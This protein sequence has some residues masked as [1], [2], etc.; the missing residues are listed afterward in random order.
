MQNVRWVSDLKLRVAYGVTGN[1]AIPGS[2]NYSSF[3]GGAGSTFYD[4]NGTNTSTTTGY[5]AT[6]FGIPVKWEKQKQSDVG[7]DALFLNSRLE[8]SVD[9]YVRKNSDFLFQPDVPGTF[10]YDVGKPYRNIGTLSNRGVEFSSTWRD[11]IGKDFKYDATLNLTFNKNRI[12]ELAPEFGVTSFFPA[13]PESRIGPL[14][15]H[16]QGQPMGTFYGLTLDGIYQNQQEVDNGPIQD[17][18]K[19]GRFRWKDISGPGGKPDGKIDDN[20]KGPI[21]D[22]NPKV[23][24]GLNLNLSYKSFDFTMFLQGTQG[25]EI[26]NY[27]RYFT[28]FFGFSGNRSKRMLYDSWTPTHTDAKLPLLGHHRQQLLPEHLLH[29]RRLIYTC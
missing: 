9:Y 18:K 14:V 5:T 15:R 23:I 1:D 2:V 17:G 22:P 12:D 4:I 21:G 6:Q 24:F 8:L 7:V 13:I 27:T 16:Y 26:F 25:N 10:P 29:R 19:I 11:G 20:D 28:D 3:G